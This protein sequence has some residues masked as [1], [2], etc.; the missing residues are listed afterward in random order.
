MSE[1]M[2]KPIFDDDD[3]CEASDADRLHA[4]FNKLFHSSS[5]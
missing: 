4:Q 1:E 5:L 3:E 2:L